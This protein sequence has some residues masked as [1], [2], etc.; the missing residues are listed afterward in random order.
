MQCN[1]MQWNVMYVYV[2]VYL[3]ICVCVQS[4]DS[5]H[6][7]CMWSLDSFDGIHTLKGA[8]PLLAWQAKSAG[9]NGFTGA[10]GFFGWDFYT[11][12]G[13]TGLTRFHRLPNACSLFATCGTLVFCC[14]GFHALCQ[15]KCIKDQKVPKWYRHIFKSLHVL[16]FCR[17]LLVD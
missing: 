7:I 8:V 9:G 2:Y 17:F 5:L 1:A 4:P 15:I 10:S 12:D 11:R 14:C 3:Y 13:S 6:D 16:H